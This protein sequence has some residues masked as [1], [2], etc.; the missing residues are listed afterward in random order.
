MS[1]KA[2]PVRPGD[3][4]EFFAETDL[5]GVLSSCPGGA[6]G[7]TADKTFEMS[8]TIQKYFGLDVMMHLT[9]TNMPSDSIKK[10][11]SDAQKNNI[12]NILAL[13]GDP[14]DGSSSWKTNDSGFNYGV[15]LVKFIRK[16]H[17]NNFF[18]RF[19]LQ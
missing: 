9:C 6:G 8:K 7:S 18:Y 1:M 15:D 5:I 12:S 3:F 11:L 14:P 4:I 17:G 13:R 16:E 19:F 10:V 2:S